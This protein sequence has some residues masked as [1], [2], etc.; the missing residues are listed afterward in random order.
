MTIDYT[1]E[2]SID[3]KIEIIKAANLQ[4]I[5][6]AFFS[7]ANNIAR[8]NADKRKRELAC[9]TATIAQFFFCAKSQCYACVNTLLSRYN[10][11]STKF[12]V[13]ACK[14]SKFLEL[15]KEAEK[16]GLLINESGAFN[17][18]RGF[19]ERFLSLG[20]KT[21]SNIFPAVFNQALKF[22]F[23]FFSASYSDLGGSSVD[24]SENPSN[25]KD[26]AQSENKEKCTQ[27]SNYISKDIDKNKKVAD[28]KF[29]KK[30]GVDCDLAYTLQQAA[31]NQSLIASG[32]KK[33]ME[34]HAKYKV[35][36]GKSFKGYL[37]WLINHS[38]KTAQNTFSI[39]EARIEFMRSHER[40]VIKN[41]LT[42]EQAQAS[43]NEEL[44]QRNMQPAP[45]H[46]YDFFGV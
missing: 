42:A 7:Q 43:L 8:Y 12:G 30:F 35:P 3:S 41:G 31:K 24:K 9:I 39:T 11:L 21:I 15:Q 6:S 22:S 23:P 19:K 25:G 37:Q 27:R 40:W 20:L 1:S 33:L 45:V 5:S 18:K 36:M 14:R 13:R 29:Y 26:H 10:E 16:L 17:P 38:G 34:L 2:L 32:A 4:Y 46:Y 44:S 28:A